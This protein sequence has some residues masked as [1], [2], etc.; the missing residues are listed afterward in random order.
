MAFFKY[1]LVNV[2]A[3]EHLLG[4]SALTGN[5]LCVF[6]DARGLGDSEMMALTRQFNLSE[7][8]FVL[9]PSS[10]SSSADARMRIFTPT[11]DP[12]LAEMRFAGHP[13]LGSAHVVRSLLGS[14]DNRVSLELPAGL[15]PVQAEGDVW[16]L[17]APFEGQPIVHPEAMPAEEIAALV[18]LQA[19]DLAGPP[20]WLDTGMEQFLIPVKS[21]AHVRKAA[22]S[23]AG[24]D[25]WPRSR[26]G[27]RNAYVFAFSG[28]RIEDRD[29][30]MARFFIIAP[31][32]GLYEDPGTGSA[33]ANLGGWLLHTGHRLPARILVEQGVE[34]QRPC[35]L[36][37]DVSTDGKVR[38][39]GR[40]TEV[41]TGTVTLPDRA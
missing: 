3:G 30:V 19:D 16:T 10:P 28:D 4:A 29:Q 15:V 34:M 14:G 26:S 41:A 35:R 32:S 11:H 38:V 39:G 31:G 1:R 17:T 13:T 18:G 24:M 5:P 33:C 6:E 36:L 40:V 12:N 7:T 9:P 8:T 21:P 20:V 22:P 37:L 25:N 23:A 27:R 2:F